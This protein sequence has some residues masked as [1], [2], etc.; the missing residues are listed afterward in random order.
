MKST[1]IKSKATEYPKMMISKD[2]GDI[3]L[4]SKYGTGTVVRTGDW[5]WE[6]GKHGSC[7]N[8]ACFED[9][10]GKVLLDGGCPNEEEKS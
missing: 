1:I 7:W 2:T 6:M 5:K 4:F 3:V 9:F 10:T 8:M